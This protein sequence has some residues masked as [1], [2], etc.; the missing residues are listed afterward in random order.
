[1]CGICGF[2]YNKA[3]NRAIDNA[4]LVIQNMTNTLRHRGPDAFGVHVDHQIALGSTRLAIIDLSPLGNQPLILNGGEHVITFNGEIYNYLELRETL[5]RKGARFLTDTDTEVLLRL[6]IEKGV[7]CLGELR[8]MFAFAI[9]DRQKKQLF[10]ARDR[11]GEKPLVY[12]YHNGLFC[13]GSEI[14][15]LLAHPMIPREIDPI[16][17]HFGMHYITVPAP[18]SAFKYIRKLKPAEYMLISEEGIRT[19]CY[20]RPQFSRARMI[21]DVDEVVF[22]LTRC[23]D[24]TVRLLCRSNVPIGAMLSGGLDSSA[25]VASMRRASRD[26]DTFSIGIENAQNDPDLLA[27]RQVA[28]YLGTRHHELAFK[29]GDLHVV[30]QVIKSFDEPVATLNPLHAHTISTTIQGH[31]KVA[32]TGNGGD[33]LFGGYIDHLSLADI[34]R[35]LSRWGMAEKLGVRCLAKWMPLRSIHRSKKKYDQLRLLPLNRIAA[36]QRLNKLQAFFSQFYSHRMN[37][38]IKD[39]DLEGLLVG[40]FNECQ[41]ESIFDG[42][43]YQ[44]LMAL[45]QHSIVDIPDHSGMANSV[46]YRS[47]F[48]DVKMIELAM[49]I[50]KHLKV[51][52]RHKT[53]KSKWILRQVLKDRLPPMIVQMGKIGFGSTIPYRS[54]MYGPWRAYIE[55]KLGSPLLRDSGLFDVDKLL[56]HYKM[57]LT[58]AKTSPE[59][60]WGIVSISQWLEIYFGGNSGKYSVLN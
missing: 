36:V 2:F 54:W 12:S 19:D 44:Q 33:E 56:E 50:P 8:G 6:Y 49:R 51:R 58:G 47:P 39:S 27:A 30:E 48:L 7:S 28:E 23:L 46:E 55:E 21:R 10:L 1:M 9:W 40:R 57:S 18:Y 13:F 4:H 15:A 59:L 53:A 5:E 16:G 41:A 43:L 24:D 20:W 17:V 11:V 32:L 22:E 35:R 37:M 25:V 31:V 38:L 60:L 26:V 29:H 52:A 3:F 45:S 34:E 42:F 14:K